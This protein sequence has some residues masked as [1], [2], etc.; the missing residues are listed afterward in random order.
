MIG[1]NKGEIALVFYRIESNELKATRH[2]LNTPRGEI[3]LMP[4]RIE[5]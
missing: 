5:R 4:Y 3:T 2:F 1:P